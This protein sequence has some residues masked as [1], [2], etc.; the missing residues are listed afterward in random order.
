M[1]FNLDACCEVYSN[2]ATSLGLTQPGALAAKNAELLVETVRGM[3]VDFNLPTHLSDI[4]VKREELE[5]MAGNALLDHCHKTNPKACAL[6][7]MSN[8][9]NLAF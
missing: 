7:D 1:E 2:I 8:I 5:P 3:C 9:L 4:G 6:D